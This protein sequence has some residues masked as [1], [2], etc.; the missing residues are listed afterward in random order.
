MKK[1]FILRA[2]I[3]DN[4][5][6]DYTITGDL[7]TVKAAYDRLVADLKERGLEAEE[8]DDED[9]FFVVHESGTTYKVTIKENPDTVDDIIKQLDNC[10]IWQ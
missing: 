8:L 9:G 7:D 2:E 4:V 10:G 6:F 1:N 5:Y 3:N